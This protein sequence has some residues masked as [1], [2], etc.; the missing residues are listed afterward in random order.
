MP[1]TTGKAGEMDRLSF[2]AAHSWVVVYQP[3]RNR[4]FADV[5]ADIAIQAQQGG[6]GHIGSRSVSE[7]VE[8]RMLGP[9]PP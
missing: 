2:F 1:F 8:V 4:A 7:M 3:A 6:L 5:D 9:K